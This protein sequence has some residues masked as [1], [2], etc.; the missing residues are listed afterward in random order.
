MSPDCKSIYI[1][2]RD[3]EAIAVLMHR[4]FIRG[5][6]MLGTLL[7]PPIPICRD[8]APE[9]PRLDRE[10]ASAFLLPTRLASSDKRKI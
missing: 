1:E 8:E 2:D 6:D 9:A 4:D 3:I 7:F 5:Q 10:T